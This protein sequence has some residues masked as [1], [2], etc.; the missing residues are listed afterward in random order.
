MTTQTSLPERVRI[1]PAQFEKRRIASLEE[2]EDRI[3]EFTRVASE[4]GAQFAVFPEL[5]T[6]QTLSLAPKLLPGD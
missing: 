3:D 1:A 5:Y 6:L 4:Q 2:F